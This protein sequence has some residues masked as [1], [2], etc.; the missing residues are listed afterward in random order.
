MHSD[1]IA[2]L[3]YEDYV[4]FKNSLN[5]IHKLQAEKVQ[6][7]FLKVLKGTKIYED[8]EKHNI[9]YRKTAPYEVISTRYINIKELLK[10]KR[11]EEIVDKYYNENYFSKSLSYVINR[12]YHES[13]FDFY[14]DFSQYW[15]RNNLFR[16]SHSRKKLYEIFYKYMKESKRQS[17]DFIDYLRY[18]YVFNNQYEEIPKFLNKECEEDFKLLKRKLANNETFREGYFSDWDKDEKLINNFRIVKIG[19]DLILFIY[20]K[21]DNIF[22]RCETNNINHMIKGYDYE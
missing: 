19:V 11:I 13:P 1:L 7:G 12:F 16:V 15:Q 8:R 22:N 2:G 9:K 3:P 5:G 10:L 20:K 6:L 18:D 14:E 17:N 4:T 21:K